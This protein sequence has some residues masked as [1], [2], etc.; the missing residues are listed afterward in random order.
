MHRLDKYALSNGE[1][2]R[3][4]LLK[5]RTVLAITLVMAIATG[6]VF[7]RLADLDLDRRASEPFDFVS[8]GEAISGTLWLPDEPPRAAVVFV[9]GDGPQDRTSAGEYRTREGPL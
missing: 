8:S 2:G 5:L 3:W 6:L 9:H 4:I 7:W 1:T